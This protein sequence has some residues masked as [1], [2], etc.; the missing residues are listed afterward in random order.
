MPGLQ[1]L[2]CLENN[3]DGGFSTLTDGFSV[4]HYLKETDPDIY[5]L[6]LTQPVNFA[7]KG[8]TSDYRIRAPLFCHNEKG[9]LDEIRWTCWLRA[10]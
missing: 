4:A 3:T 1:F 10:P 8:Q 7:N 9:N 2:Y 5:Q 6:L